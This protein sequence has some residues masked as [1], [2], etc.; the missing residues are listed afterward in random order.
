MPESK[1][2]EFRVLVVTNLWPTEEDPGYGSFVQAQVESLW[3]L[4]VD[5]D[6]LFINGRESK[7]NYR[8]GIG[9]MRR[10]LRDKH[11]DLI[12]AHFGLSGWVARRQRQVPVV[13]SLMGDDV[14]GRARAD[15]GVTPYGRLLRATGFR[16]A[17]KVDAV[18]VKS[19]AMKQA[20]Q[21]ETAHVIPNGVDLELFRPMPR[22]EAR[23]ALGLS[24][25]KKFVFFPYNPLERNK[26]FDLI[27][28]AVERAR[29]SVPE[30]DILEVRGE[31]RSRMPLF[32]NAADVVVLASMFEGS[33]NVLKEAM[34]VNLPVVTVDVGDAR[35]RI[36][37]AEGCYLVARDADAMASRIVEVCRGG[38][39]ANSR[40]RVAD[41]SMDEVARKIVEVYAAVVGH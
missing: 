2:P 7:W 25:E 32:L 37:G 16:V 33:P 28:D 41:L 13:V 11:F 17:R 31:P 29:K 8:R 23:R 39:R 27:Q 15:G 30:I 24:L 22:E 4:G 26:R 38:Q 9:E 1:T 6:V 19:Q 21:L 14:F 5:S 40:S 3:P 12:H 34:A 36:A 20:L 18:I 10:R 35:E